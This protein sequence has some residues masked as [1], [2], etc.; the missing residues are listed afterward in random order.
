ME[1]MSFT[2]T[3]GDVMQ[4]VE[5]SAKREVEESRNPSSE[6]AAQLPSEPTNDRAKIVITIQDKDGQKTL[7]VFAVSF[8]TACHLL[9]NLP[10]TISLLSK[11]FLA[12]Y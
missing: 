5:E 7:R 9:S 11:L 1:L 8:F 12:R 4:E 6:T 10:S 3:V 2:K